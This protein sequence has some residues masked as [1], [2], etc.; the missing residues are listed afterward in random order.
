MTNDRI[1]VHDYDPLAEPDLGDT[2]NQRAAVRQR[3]AHTMLRTTKRRRILAQTMIAIAAIL[4]TGAAEATIQ[5]SLASHGAQAS[6]TT[7]AASSS[8]TFAALRGVSANLNADQ[9][10]IANLIAATNTALHS[11]RVG[12][13]H[14]PNVSPKTPNAA[15]V[16]AAVVTPTPPV[17]HAT[18]GASNSG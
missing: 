9:R 11:T 14:V 2:F 1:Y 16:N 13:V 12:A 3:T 8:D 6:A 5:H 17:T 15:A 4:G 7:A 10:A 18:T